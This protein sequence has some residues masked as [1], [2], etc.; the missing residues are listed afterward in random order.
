M[1]ICLLEDSYEK[2]LL[3]CKERWL[4]V[5]SAGGEYWKGRS[6]GFI[7]DIVYN[8]FT[9]D[10]YV[11]MECGVCGRLG[12]EEGR[13]AQEIALNELGEVRTVNVLD[14]IECAVF[15]GGEGVG[16]VSVWD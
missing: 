13:W 6:A 14:G 7:R 1:R 9:A 15:A 10:A 5:H 3:G 8:K 12:L 11:A 16:K 2:I 4:E